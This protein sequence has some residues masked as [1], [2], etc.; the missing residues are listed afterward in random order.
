MPSHPIQAVFEYICFYDGNKQPV[1]IATYY[2]CSSLERRQT[3]V[4]ATLVALLKE[5]SMRPIPFRMQL[6]ASYR[7]MGN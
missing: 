7:F 5:E 1:L 4:E 3:D 2:A 6:P